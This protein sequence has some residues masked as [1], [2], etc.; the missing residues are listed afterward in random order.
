MGLV[1]LRRDARAPS[2]LARLRAL[3]R[4]SVATMRS[5]V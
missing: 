2:P 4:L 3:L 1:Y 5:L